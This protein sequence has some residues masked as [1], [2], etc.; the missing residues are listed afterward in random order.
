ML[1]LLFNQNQKS[2][3]EKK[4]NLAAL[5]AKINV[6]KQ[7]KKNK[8]IQNILLDFV[9]LSVLINSHFLG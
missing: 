4:N 5:Q 3:K 6:M 9:V 7:T 8:F 2:T 1:I